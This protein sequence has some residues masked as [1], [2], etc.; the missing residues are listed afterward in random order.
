[1][2]E[3]ADTELEVALLGPVRAW[4]GGAELTLGPARQRAVLA[5]L[6][7][8]ANHVV[9]RA[10]VIDA[11]W[12]SAAPASAEGSVHTY[13][14]GL[15]RCLDPDR[16]RWSAGAV[17]L[18][19]GAGYLLN[20]ATS[21]VVEFDEH[22]RAAE[23]LAAEG[24]HA[25]AVAAFDAAL[26]LWQGEAYSGIPGPYA[27]SERTRLAGQ[28]VDVFEHRAASMLELGRTTEVIAELTTVVQ[29]HP[30][31]ESLWE[32]ILL[33][34]YRG[35][36]RTEALETFQRA[37]QVLLAEL[38]TE[39]GEA[40]R[41]VHERILTNDPALTPGEDGHLQVLPTHVARGRKASQDQLFVGRSRESEVLRKLVDDVLLGTGRAVW[42]EGEA[43][44]GKSELLAE[45]LADAGERGCQLAW[46]VAEELGRR[47]PLQVISACLGL[48]TADGP[49][50]GDHDDGDPVMSTVD[51]LLAMVDELCARAPLVLVVDD[52][53][54]ADEASVLMWH[55]LCAA[56]RQQPLLLVAATRPAADR[57]EL[58]QLRR[59]VEARDG[60]VL[61]LDPLSEQHAE[62]LMTAVIG[63]PLGP[64]LRALAARAPGNPLY[65]RETT[66]ALVKGDAVDFTGGAA[67]LKDPTGYTLPKSVSGAV[68]RTLE[69]LSP[70]T[71]HAL[72]W[73]ALL[74]VEFAVSDVATVLG[75][76]PSELVGAFDEAV[77]GRVVIDAG[78]R[79]TFRHPLLRQALY[80]S[81]PGAIRVSWHRQAAEALARADAPVRQVAEQLVTVP[82]LADPWVLDWLA[83]NHT[84]VATRAPLIA[85]EL[86]K[87]V[88]DAGRIDDPR[89]EVLLFALVRVLF[90]LQRNPETLARQALAVVTDPVRAIELRHLLAA[91]LHRRGETKTALEVLGEDDPDVPA[92]WNERRRSLAANFGRG[93][94]SDLNAAEEAAHRAYEAALVSAE[95][96]PIA[97]AQ[98]TLWLVQSIRRDH[99]QALA[100]VDTALSV[101]NSS[102]GVAGLHFDLL[103]NRIFTLQNLDRLDDAEATLRSAREVAQRY[104]LPHGLQVSAAVQHY[105]QGRWDEALVELD[106]V[107]EDGPA[108]TF[109]GLREPGPA[110]LLL[111]GVAALIAGRRDETFI[112]AG[113]L[114]AAE[115]YAPVTSSERESC[116][117]LLVAQALSAEQRG[118]PGKAIELLAPIL[119]PTYAQMMLRHQWLP[120]LARLALQTGEI[121]TAKHALRVCE[122]EA[123][124]EV[125]PARAAAAAARCRALLSGDEEPML[126]VA[127]HYRRV[128]RYL[129]M[130]SALEDAAVLLARDNRP[131]NARSALEQ[132]ISEFSRLGARWD[133]RRAETRLSALGVTAG[134]ARPE[135]RPSSG[136]ASL[137]DVEVEIAHLVAE[138]RSNPDIASELA[139]PRRTVQAHVAR[140]LG[141][142]GVK[143]RNGVVEVVHARA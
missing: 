96:Y 109:H 129:E 54:W 36:R 53:Q 136:W 11:V 142:L 40:L 18:S 128:G 91:L 13:V 110:A 44:I 16:S 31:R 112:A 62:E 105:W 125:H 17:L 29:R 37:R 75:K 117:F 115:E 21:D 45:A 101:V 19:E 131:E 12:G 82:A 76:L 25:G 114:D 14:S 120:D 73:A 4:R 5:V 95:P 79:L 1:M 63:A 61:L 7:S 124:K 60:K 140:L 65:V 20:V 15:R 41:R 80:D 72:R 100:H 46:A 98:Q 50:A 28:R 10:E 102:P 133:I 143:S 134:R 89:R 69:F 111:H 32:T 127:E 126:D 51:T 33:A 88:L 97:H 56:T 27:E 106:T 52:L 59:G 123:A 104:R 113:H 77:S 87:Q 90:R 68:G 108:I 137:S 81:I 48:D 30:L 71:Q 135:V 66:E 67:D 8:R 3:P 2:A 84:A 47:F 35:G 130:A 64:G 121:E 42:I 141:K 116:D 94:L 49:L 55:R 9:T 23:R 58:A 6:A 24:D 57:P 118:E 34:L 43:G 107:T 122:E 78:A 139:L 70:G 85:A 22:R 103:D 74:G 99:P 38:G 39:P 93:D 86:L 132:A 83:H 92:L 26:A 138:G 119:D